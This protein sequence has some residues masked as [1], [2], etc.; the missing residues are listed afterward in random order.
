[1]ERPSDPNRLWAWL[2]KQPGLIRKVDVESSPV[3]APAS[4]ELSRFTVLSGLH[5]SGKSYLL[6]VIGEGLRRWQV[7]TN[8]PIEDDPEWQLQ[9]N[10]RLHLRDE[11]TPGSVEV[12]RP[13]ERSARDTQLESIGPL[14]ATRLTPF[15]AL[16]ELAFDSANRTPGREE[17]MVDVRHLSTR[18]LAALRRIT[19]YAYANMVYGTY[20]NPHRTLPHFSGERDSRHVQSFMMSASEFWVHFV[21]FNLRHAD[22]NEIV[23]IDEPETFLAQPGH[24]AFIDEIARLTAESGCQTVVATHSESMISR[25]PAT[26]V[27]L[28]SSTRAG[29]VAS[30]IASSESL[31]RALGRRAP[32]IRAIVFVEDEMG[33]RILKAIIRE[34]APEVMQLIE[35]VESGGKDEVR[36]GVRVVA[37]AKRIKAAGVL[38]GDQR[39]GPQSADIYLLPGCSEPESHLLRALSDDQDAAASSLQVA[40]S[41]LRLALENTRF[42][43]HQRV[44]TTMSSSLTGPSAAEVVDCALRLWLRDDEV[45]AQA[46][47]LADQIRRLVERP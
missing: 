22:E 33:A 15:V 34:E 29:S 1:M 9:G 31:L 45:R 24:V 12:R 38:D 25:V 27:L 8:L 16:S 6:A 11:V 28:V 4:V 23:L 32:A 43:P 30:P 7:N 5:G 3:L 36:A 2:T 46:R 47:V 14:Y 17:P 13:M 18:D 40:A 37:R 42:V 21:L 35:I 44:F 19:G 41:D 39:G 26:S 10:Y 20:E